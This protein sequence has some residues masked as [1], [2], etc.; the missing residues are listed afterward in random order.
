MEYHIVPHP[1][2]SGRSETKIPGFV[3]SHDFHCLVHGKRFAD[4]F[5]RSRKVTQ[6][7]HLAVVL[8]DMPFFRSDALAFPGKVPW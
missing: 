4:L 5:A 3:S 8:E 1:T 6:Y 7:Y 2:S